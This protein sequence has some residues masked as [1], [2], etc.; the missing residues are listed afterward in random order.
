MYRDTHIMSK[1]H[2]VA[3]S[4]LTYTFSVYKYSTCNTQNVQFIFQTMNTAKYSQN[5][6]NGNTWS[7]QLSINHHNRTQ[8]SNSTDKK[9]NIQYTKISYPPK[10]LISGRSSVYA[11]KHDMTSSVERATSAYNANC[12]YSTTTSLPF[13][14]TVGLKE[15]RMPYFNDPRINMMPLFGLERGVGQFYFAMV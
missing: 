8:F 5:H 13:I 2:S 1:E 11:L 10:G 3:S 14:V 6:N 15:L 7:L 9:L 12:R 4:H